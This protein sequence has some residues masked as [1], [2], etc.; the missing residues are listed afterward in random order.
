MHKFI[1]YYSDDVEEIFRRIRAITRNFDFQA[2]GTLNGQRLN[3]LL[4]KLEDTVHR[5]IEQ[6]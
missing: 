3:K 5:I 2:Y 4:D 6:L 1:E